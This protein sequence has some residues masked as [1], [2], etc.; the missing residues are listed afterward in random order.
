MIKQHI[1]IVNLLI[2][3]IGFA[4]TP[5]E[6]DIIDEISNENEFMVSINFDSPTS[7]SAEAG[8]AGV[9]ILIPTGFDEVVN[10]DL[11][12]LAGGAWTVESY[13]TAADVNG[14]CAT[15]SNT[16]DV[17]RIVNTGTPDDI[18]N[19]LAGES[20]N[21][22]KISLSGVGPTDENIKVVNPGA[23]IGT[24]EACLTGFGM[25]NT[26]DI[27]TDGSGPIPSVQFEDIA[28]GS[29]AILPITLKSFDATKKSER[30]VLLDWRSSSEINASHYEVQ[31]LN[32][33]NEWK[34]LNIITAKGNA[35]IS[36]EYSYLDTEI[37]LKSVYDSDNSENHVGV[38][39]RLKMVDLDGSV[40]YSKVEIVSLRDYIDEFNVYP[41]PT[42]EEVYVSIANVNELGG[43][44]TIVDNK[45][46]VYLSKTLENGNNERISTINMP[47][48]IY[49]FTVSQGDNSYS[50][51]IMKMD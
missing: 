19:L 39:Y 17:V 51:K 7:S 38:N 35:D 11:S 1:F 6:Y 29:Q 43:T 28:S 30:S 2:A 21:L 42:I 3:S 41:N 44:L 50:K 23:A 34:S 25:K 32:K 10:A 36:A 20:K 13:L 26:I 40:E 5:I 47:S 16:M 48:G 9:V 14:P 4:Q 12:N 24:L 22:V 49:I 27:D 15:P 8:N 45:G 31:R 33:F 37:D 46:T 18:S